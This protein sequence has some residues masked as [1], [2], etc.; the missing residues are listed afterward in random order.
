MNIDLHN[1]HCTKDTQCRH[2]A[3]M[4]MV[5]NYIFTDDKNPNFYNDT[6]N[7]YCNGPKFPGHFVTF[8]SNEP[9]H[10]SAVIDFKKYKDFMTYF[11]SLSNNVIRDY[12]IS[13]IY[14]KSYD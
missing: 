9:R 3:V 13:E 7:E 6:H 11:N 10:L 8:N 2:F 4:F 5:N 12:K 14:N 1:E